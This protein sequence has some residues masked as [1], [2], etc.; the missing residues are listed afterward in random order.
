MTANH[1]HAHNLSNLTHYWMIR[2]LTFGPSPMLV[3][4]GSWS[5]SCVQ[6]LNIFFFV[7]G[8]WKYYLA[9]EF[10]YFLI[11]L[12]FCQIRG[13][14]EKLSSHIYFDL[15]EKRIIARRRIKCSWICFCAVINNFS[16]SKCKM[17]ASCSLYL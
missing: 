9:S 14:K 17:N 7:E 6:L 4:T 8:V 16:A 5:W 13:W 3:R 15:F 10:L 1:T 12:F 2:I 11:I